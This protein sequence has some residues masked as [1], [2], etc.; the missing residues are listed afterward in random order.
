MRDAAGAPIA[1][2]EVQAKDAGGETLWSAT[3]DEA[4]NTPPQPFVT[5]TFTGTRKAAG[6]PITVTATKPGYA[7]GRVTA[8][9][10]EGEAVTI[11]IRPE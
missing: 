9:A 8:P 5:A 1:G 4:G 3:T 10:T 7:P 6:A 2:A 11:S